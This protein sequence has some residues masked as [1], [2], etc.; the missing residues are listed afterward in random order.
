MQG[1]GKY[2]YDNGCIY[3][4]DWV[5]SKM[6]GSGVYTWPDNRSYKG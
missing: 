5:N 1:I 4:G 6:E 2:I 3:E